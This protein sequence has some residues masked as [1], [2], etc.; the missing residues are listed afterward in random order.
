MKTQID[1]IFPSICVTCEMKIIRFGGICWRAM[2]DRVLHTMRS[3]IPCYTTTD[4]VIR[5]RGTAVG[6][7]MKWKYAQRALPQSIPTAITVRHCGSIRIQ[8]TN[9][10]IP[11]GLV[12]CSPSSPALENTGLNGLHKCV[13]CSFLVAYCSDLSHLLYSASPVYTNTYV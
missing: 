2:T 9:F 6:S 7:W 11:N 3:G 12:K 13:F 1:G 10:R 4:R 5:W 8:I